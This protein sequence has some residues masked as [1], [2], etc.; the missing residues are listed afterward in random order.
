LLV[1]DNRFVANPGNPFKSETA[2]AAK[3]NQKL[4]KQK[5]EITKQI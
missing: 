1:K 5:A 4:G 2:K 3:T